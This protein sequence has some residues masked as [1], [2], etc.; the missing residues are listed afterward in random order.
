MSRKEF[1]KE[2]VKVPEYVCMRDENSGVEIDA[3]YPT[4]SYYIGMIWLHTRTCPQER[5]HQR[6]ASARRG[7][8]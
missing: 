2:R 7:R 3:L 5:D 8:P 1:W 4:P 6:R